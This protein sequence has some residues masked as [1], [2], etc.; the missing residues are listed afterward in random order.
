MIAASCT[1]N[2]IFLLER[3]SGIKLKE[4]KG[5]KVKDFSID[6]QFTQDDSHILT[7]SE[8]GSLYLYNIVKT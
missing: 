5:H 4:Y 3:S 2:S 6:L 7:G 8:D 1:N